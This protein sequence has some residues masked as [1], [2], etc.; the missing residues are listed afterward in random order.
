MPNEYF[1]ERDFLNYL[2]FIKRVLYMAHVCVKL[3]KSYQD[4]YD[5]SF[6]SESG[7]VYKPYLVMKSKSSSSFEIRFHFMAHPDTF[8]FHRFNPTVNNVRKKF[9]LDKSS[10]DASLPTPHY[11]FEILNDLRSFELNKVLNET[12]TISKGLIDGLKLLKLWLYQRQ[13]NQVCNLIK[14]REL[15]LMID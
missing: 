1:K 10:D 15:Y 6:E 11:N 14:K 13:L 7:S 5:F 12:L 8:N 9:I 3:L 2:Y 4:S